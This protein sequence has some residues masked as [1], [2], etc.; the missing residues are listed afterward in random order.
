[1]DKNTTTTAPLDDC[2]PDCGGETRFVGAFDHGMTLPKWRQEEL[3]DH[4]A[5]TQC[6]YTDPPEE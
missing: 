2:C 3:K 5:C 6:D 1:M 4:T